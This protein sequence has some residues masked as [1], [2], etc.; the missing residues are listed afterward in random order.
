MGLRAIRIAREGLSTHDLVAGWLEEVG[1]EDGDGDSTEAQKEE[2]LI[3]CTP[4][5]HPQLLVEY[6][7]NSPTTSFSYE[8]VFDSPGATPT[9]GGPTSAKNRHHSYAETNASSIHD[10]VNPCDGE[11][12]LQCLVL[13]DD[14]LDDEQ[15]ASLASYDPP[16]AIN[17]SSHLT[18]HSTN[19]ALFSVSPHFDPHKPR[20]IWITSCLQCT[21]AGLPC[22][23]SSPACSRCMR[24][25][26]SKLCLL[27]RRRTREEMVNGDSLLNTTPIL[28][29]AHGD[30]ETVW[31][32]KIRLA[33]EVRHFLAVLS[34]YFSYSR[35]L[36]RERLLMSC[37]V[38]RGVDG[39]RGEEEL[40][41]PHQR[42]EDWQ[43]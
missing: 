4:L 35:K 15:S 9:E 7:E 16:S 28:L 37:V 6:D 30:D 21:L 5:R 18:I 10:D 34:T 1:P 43:L 32:Q 13:P 25:G 24:S 11:E 19:L 22:S 39:E 31:Q 8:S 40:G 33:Q 17:S 29:K 23:R 2:K 27:H 38:A 14:A 20:L 42:R 36:L 26:R 41:S 12:D 3:P